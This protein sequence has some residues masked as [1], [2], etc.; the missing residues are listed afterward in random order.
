MIQDLNE[1][2]C[3]PVERIWQQPWVVEWTQL[4]LE[5]YRYWTHHDLIGRNGTP[6]EQ[7]HQVFESRFVVVS[8]GMEDE[9]VLNYGNRA[10]L[11]LW[12]MNWEELT[13]TPSRLTA[14]P[15]NQAERAR[16]L[17]RAGRQ[18]FIADYRGVRISKTG[19]RFLVEG[20]VVWNVVDARGHQRGQAATFSHW[21]PIE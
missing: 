8:H 17:Q 10:A 14:E 21:K 3:Q 6:P 4:L 2:P 20:A 9:P 11:A 15:L 13:R 19:K 18:G 16:M 12:E 5:S 1:S 7:S